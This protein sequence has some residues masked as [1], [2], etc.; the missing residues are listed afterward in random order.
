MNPSQKP[1][2]GWRIGF[3]RNVSTLV[4]IGIIMVLVGVFSGLIITN[5]VPS[6]ELSGIHKYTFGFDL[7]VLS[8]FVLYGGFVLIVFAFFMYVIIHTANPMRS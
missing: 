7:F 8:R 3:Q 2:R 1:S 4:W 6:G 5:I